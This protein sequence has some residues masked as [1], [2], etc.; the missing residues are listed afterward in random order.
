MPTWLKIAP[1]VLAVAIPASA[2]TPCT[3]A[4]S[5]PGALVSPL[6][7]PTGAFKVGRSAHYVKGSP[8]AGT[9][10]ATDL[11]LYAWYPADPTAAG[12]PVPYLAGWPESQTLLRDH[13]QRMLREAFCA[14]E[15]GR[16][17]SHAELTVRT[18]SQ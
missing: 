16:V 12:R 17:F 7:A 1:L 2:Q 14:F 18:S 8:G 4:P 3:A 10:A 11:M 6:P 13:A 5:S 9:A 15:Q